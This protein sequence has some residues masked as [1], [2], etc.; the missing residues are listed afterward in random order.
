MWRWHG[1]LMQ[2]HVPI[3]EPLLGILFS[4]LGLGAAIFNRGLVARIYAGDPQWMPL[5]WGVYAGVAALLTVMWFFLY[6]VSLFTLGIWAVLSALVGGAVLAE[7]W[8]LRCYV[9]SPG[10]MSRKNWPMR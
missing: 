5:V 8:S 9:E 1:L 6:G 10:R 4:F 3:W 2:T 7:M